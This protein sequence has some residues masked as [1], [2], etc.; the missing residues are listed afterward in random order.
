MATPKRC[1]THVGGQHF[2][3]DYYADCVVINHN[4]SPPSPQSTPAT[5]Y[6]VGELRRDDWLNGDLDFTQWPPPIHKVRQHIRQH[7]GGM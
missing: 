5:P 4:T 6:V 1:F 2:T 3:L 7:Y